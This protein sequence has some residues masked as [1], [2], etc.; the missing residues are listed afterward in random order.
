MV[1]IEITIVVTVEAKYQDADWL[2]L[3]VGCHIANVS[4]GCLRRV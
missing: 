2:R 4:D 1:V 3:S